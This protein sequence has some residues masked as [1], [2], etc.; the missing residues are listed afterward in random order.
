MKLYMQHP[1]TLPRRAFTLVELLVVLTVILLLMGLVWASIGKVREQATQTGCLSNQRQL[2]LANFG[3][4]S[5]NDGT[6]MS[7]RSDPNYDAG[8]GDTS[9][10]ADCSRGGEEYRLFTKSF[11]S[12]GQD[13]MYTDENGRPQE[14]DLALTDGAAWE[15]LGDTKVYKSPLDPTSRLRSYAFNAYVG[16]I[17]P[18][19]LEVGGIGGL[20]TTGWRSARTLSGLPKPNETLMTICEEDANDQGPAYN[21]QG[22]VVKTWE[23]N[24]AW[25]DYPAPWLKD[26][27]T[28]SFCDGS[29]SFYK[30][31]APDLG[32]ILIANSEPSF[33]YHR[34][35]YSGEG[36]ESDLLW[37]QEHMLPGRLTY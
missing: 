33:G 2:N 19:N 29:T 8:T 12:G 21:N 5:D 1:T 27:V 37:F 4:A 35:T 6:F 30:F 23:D 34:A 15:Y 31:K 16:E 11:D 20:L 28:L 36:G 18:D 32:N 9:D 3:F 17:C 14:Y 24:Q 10:L 13:R 22:W 7:P 25:W 26:G